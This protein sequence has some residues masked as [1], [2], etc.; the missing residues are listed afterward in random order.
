MLLEARFFLICSGDDL[1]GKGGKL[2]TTRPEL[3]EIRF[4]IEVSCNRQRKQP[5]LGYRSLEFKTLMKA[6]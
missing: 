3:L 1:S 4:C 5:A 6:A 2:L